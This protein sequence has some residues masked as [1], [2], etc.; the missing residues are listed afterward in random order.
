EAQK[1][2]LLNRNK[3]LFQEICQKYIRGQNLNDQELGILKAN[4]LSLNS[5]SGNL[6]RDIYNDHNI[7]PLFNSI[8]KFS[9]NITSFFCNILEYGADIE[10]A[11]IINHTII[12]QKKF[13]PDLVIKNILEY[14]I[15]EIDDIS[16]NIGIIADV[17]NLLSNRTNFDFNHPYISYTEKTISDY[18]QYHDF[19]NEE[20]VEEIYLYNNYEEQ[21]AI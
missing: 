17:V 20:N 4:L 13:L 11:K 1:N 10:Y 3:A 18:T 8:Q 15:G 16:S 7:A 2:I 6:L 14:I 9:K 12:L 19:I 21:D 5:D